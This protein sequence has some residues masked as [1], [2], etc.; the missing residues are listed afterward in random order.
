MTF[1]KSADL[2]VG[3]DEA[4]ALVTQP[5]RLRRWQTVAATVD[6][7]VGGEYRWTVTP[8]HRAAGTFKEIEPGK[9]VVFGWGWEDG[10]LAPDAS[11]VTITLEPTDSGTRVTLTHEDLTLEEA[12]AHAEGWTHFLD[13]LEKLATTGDAG[14]DEWA[15][16][17]DPIDPLIAA[18]ASLAVLQPI[19]RGLTAEDRPKQTP[20]EDFDCHGLAEHLMG[21]LASLGEMAGVTVTRPEAGSLEDKVSVMAAQVITAWLAYDEDMAVGGHL[22]SSMAQ[23]I[24]SLELLLHGWD[25]AEASGQQ[26]RV[27][28]ELVAYVTELVTPIIVAGRDRG[29]FKPEVA[30]SGSGSALDRLAAFAGRTRIE[31]AA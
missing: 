8:G 31:Q 12:A 5:E 28:D 27:S 10:D 7:R 6:L 26:M 13:R 15:W 17:P 21:S 16:A 19:L 18:E 1:T 2:P 9:R 4:Y 30:V 25:L 11:T 23:A 20:C 24:I 3:L 14:P 22:P 29:S